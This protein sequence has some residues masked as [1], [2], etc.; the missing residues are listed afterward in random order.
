M[1]VEARSV[2]AFLSR[3]L[4]VRGVLFH[5]DD[6][7][8][9]R[10]RADQVTASIIGASDD[11]FRVAWLFKDNHPRLAEEAAALSM[12]G[13]RRV[14]RVRDVAESIAPALLRAMALP[15]DS[16]IVLE[17]EALSKR[18]KLR[19][20]TEESPDMAVIACYPAQGAELYATAR[21]LFQERGVRISDEAIALFVS[22]AGPD[23]TT[24]RGEA[25]KLAVFA[26]AGNSVEA[27][28]ILA[29]VGD[30]AGASLDDALFAATAGD[31]DAADRALETAL[32][33][34]AA[35]VAI[36]RILLGHLTRLQSVVMAVAAG[37]SP[38]T[39]VRAMRPPVMFN[40]VAALTAAAAVWRRSDIDGALAAAVAAEL[41]CK[42]SGAR[43]ILLI[44]RLVL[45]VT[46]LGA[47]NRR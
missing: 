33:S 2:A 26:G 19:A 12:T 38:G 42:Q 29:A 11:P 14:V 36:C 21:H 8:L 30:Q 28:D 32:E 44:R 24:L 31:L 43:D 25:E 45:R 5:G 27:A 22:R 13:G 16:L 46:Q 17:S 15:G 18:S 3:P 20:V 23:T 34:G 39:A 47:R 6:E 40:R 9:V 10:A 41:A 4:Q 37:D 1:R 7:A 35:A